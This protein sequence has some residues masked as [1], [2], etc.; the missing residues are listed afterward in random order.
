MATNKII[1]W[2]RRFRN[3][4]FREEKKKDI[5]KGISRLNEQVPHLLRGFEGCYYKG[6]KSTPIFET[7]GVAKSTEKDYA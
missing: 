2:K 1:S 6:G 7:G 5:S 4:R 3:C